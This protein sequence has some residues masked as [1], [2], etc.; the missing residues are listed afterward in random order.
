MHP[1]GTSC[2][3][4]ANNALPDRSN[5][6]EYRMIVRHAIHNTFSWE[7]VNQDAALYIMAGHPLCPAVDLSN[8]N[9]RFQLTTPYQHV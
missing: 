4:F 5:R 8:N 7:H 2:H 6:S 3:L 1:P 9:F